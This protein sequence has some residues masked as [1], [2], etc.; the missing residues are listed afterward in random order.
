M[1]L[2]NFF[3]QAYLSE[4]AFLVRAMGWLLRQLLNGGKDHEI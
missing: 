3:K 2:L 4:Q 1:N